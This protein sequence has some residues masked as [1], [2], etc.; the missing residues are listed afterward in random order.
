MEKPVKLHQEM[1]GYRKKNKLEITI[2][3]DLN[4]TINENGCLTLH[5]IKQ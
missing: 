4:K 5:T 3:W 2:I 1:M